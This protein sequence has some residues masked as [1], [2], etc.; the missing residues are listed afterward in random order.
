VFSK[1]DAN[2]SHLQ[3]EIFGFHVCMVENTVAKAGEHVCLYNGEELC[4]FADEVVIRV[5]GFTV[6]L[7]DEGSP[8]C[9]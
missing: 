4:R 6:S 5:R 9:A 3:R 1:W 8:C 7:H 2:A